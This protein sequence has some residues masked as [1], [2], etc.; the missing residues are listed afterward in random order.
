MSHF[1]VLAACQLPD[2]LFEEGTPAEQHELPEIP[3]SPEACLAALVTQGGLRRFDDIV[4]LLVYILL[5]PYDVECED[6]RRLQLLSAE[7]HERPKYETGSIDLVRMPDGCLIPTYSAKFSEQYELHDG[8]VY[9]RCAG[10]LHHR[11]RTKAAKRMTALPGYPIRRAYPSFAV[12]MTAMGYDYDEETQAYGFYINPHA[13]YDWYQIGAGRSH[14]FLV[15]RGCP[16]VYREKV[17]LKPSADGGD[18]DAPAGYRWVAGARKGDIQWAMMKQRQ[19]KMSTQSFHRLESYYHTGQLPS[20]A[21]EYEITEEG[22]TGPYGLIY[23][24]GEKLEDYL[25]RHGLGEDIVYPY[26]TYAFVDTHGWR[27]VDELV[28]SGMAPQE[29]DRIWRQNIQCFLASLPDDAL[30]VSLDCHI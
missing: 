8:Q 1:A 23:Q 22:I 21:S 17:G 30:L 19:V 20:E 11:K 9:Q 16:A 28:R 4:D 2:G 3:D 10:R 5:A 12:Y 24:K 7:K 15:K 25:V 18:L 13:E 27:S 26:N 14:S 29:R 6:P